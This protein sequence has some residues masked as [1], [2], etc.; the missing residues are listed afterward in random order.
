MHLIEWILGYGGGGAGGGIIKIE[1]TTHN[2]DDLPVPS[3]G[4]AGKGDIDSNRG[5]DGGDPGLLQI[6]GVWIVVHLKYKVW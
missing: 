6:N 1:A 3:G 2:A 5:G 4:A